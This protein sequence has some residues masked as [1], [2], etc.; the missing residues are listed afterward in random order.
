MPNLIALTRFVSKACKLFAYSL[1]GAACCL[2][3]VATLPFPLA[4]NILLKHF[5][6]WKLCYVVANVTI[7]CTPLCSSPSYCAHN[8]RS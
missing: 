7:T 4:R 5:A 3:Q 6:I 1:N 8:I 2:V